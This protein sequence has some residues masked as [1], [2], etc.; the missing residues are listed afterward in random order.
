MNPLTWNSRK[1]QTNLQRQQIHGNLGMGGGGRYGDECI[2]KGHE[3]PCGGDA[4]IHD[5][6]CGDDFTDAS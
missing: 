1:L 6:D 3:G 2:T 4:Y 5:L